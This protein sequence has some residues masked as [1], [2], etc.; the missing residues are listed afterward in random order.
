M[1]SASEFYASQAAICA[2]AASES[3][4]PRLRE[5]YERA[6]A[7]WATLANR[8]T[9]IAAARDRRLAEAAAKAATPQMSST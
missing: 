8:E 6:G 2:Q 4:L 5:K 7:A 3:N 9:D 1:S